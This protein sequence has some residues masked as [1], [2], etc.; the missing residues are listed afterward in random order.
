MLWTESGLVLGKN[1]YKVREIVSYKTI[2]Y[3]REKCF[4]ECSS[5]IGIIGIDY[6]EMASVFKCNFQGWSICSEKKFPNRY[7][8]GK[9]KELEYKSGGS[10]TKF[11]TG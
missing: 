6:R 3:C 11:I 7:Q 2:D 9:S 5:S 8:V 1:I 4:R 10:Q